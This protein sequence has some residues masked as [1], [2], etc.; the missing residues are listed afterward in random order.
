MA[1]LDVKCSMFSFS[2]SIIISAPISDFTTPDIIF[3]RVDFPEPFSP[4]RQ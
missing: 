4:T 2:P 1:V 3:I